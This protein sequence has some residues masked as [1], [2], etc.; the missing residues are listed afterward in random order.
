MQTER[1]I[2]LPALPGMFFR[3]LFTVARSGEHVA[4]ASEMRGTFKSAGFNNE[5]L[6]RFSQAFG[7]FISDIPLTM[8]YCLAQRVH[9]AQM[10][11]EQFPWPAPGLVH[12]SNSLQQHAPIRINQGF[13]MHATIQLPARG[14]AVSARR[15][16]PLFEVEFWQADQLVASC[17]SEYQVR[18]KN[19]PPRSAK[20][21][22][23]KQATPPGEQWQRLSSWSLDGATGRQYA[24]LSGD[25]NPIHLH[26]LLS[27]WFGFDQP[28]I[29]GMYMVA[30]AQAEIERHSGRA[31]QRLDVEFK[32]PVALPATICLWQQAELDGVQGGY[33][34]CGAD[35]HLQRLEGHFK[36][37]T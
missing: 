16:R 8:M 6:Q 18:P 5:Q 23:Q 26:P 29:H 32:R 33:Q 19:S 27:R 21:R 25:F 31:M 35:D 34:I 22:E 3:S 12:V 28:I 24:R 9:L 4:S 10:L 37:F 15:L 11:D 1:P 36:L 20:V 17:T 2:V 14:P 7:G 13:T 30:R